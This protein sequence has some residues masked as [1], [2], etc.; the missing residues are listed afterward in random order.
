MAPSSTRVRAIILFTVVGVFLAA[1]LA[2]SAT[3]RASANDPP[4]SAETDAPPA[5]D[6]PSADAIASRLVQETVSIQE[7]ESVLI[8]GS[9]RD[10]DLMESL[11]V[12]VRKQGAFPLVTLQNETMLKRMYDEVPAE[13]DRQAPDLSLKMLDIVSVI[14]DISYGET[15]GLLDEVDPARIAA[16]AEANAAVMKK[17]RER[18]IRTV[19]IGNGLYPTSALSERSGL[20]K[21]RL[22]TLFWNGVGT[23]PDLLTR[24]GEA[25]REAL[26]TGRTLRITDDNGTDL[27]MEINADR[28][29]IS[30]GRISAD[31]LDTN[32]RSVWLPAG[33]LFL[34]PEP[35]SVQGTLTS[36]LQ[37][38]EGQEIRNLQM[39]FENGRMTEMTADAG[40]DRLQALY[41]E[42]GDA[43]SEFA[44]LD[45]G[46]NRSIPAS[47]DDRLLTWMAAGMVTVGIGNDV[48][49]G[50]DNDVPFAFYTHLKG[51]TVT[52][53][54]RTIVD[55]GV[56]QVRTMKPASRE[57]SAPAGASPTAGRYD[58]TG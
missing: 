20:S 2:L 51:V 36:A 13:Y 42:S 14:I 15:P 41:R 5:T 46:L 21:D 31:D 3:D 27:R 4:I 25:V 39:T 23:D 28:A 33:E 49:A 57:A 29:R 37:Y 54:D 11:A 34:V 9:P 55:R 47:N 38:F 17:A 40:L 24:T 12:H 10:L 56:L 58:P 1:G 22:A 32:N 8:V 45:F 35:G 44:A 43:A 16:R 53:D 19:E 26:R 7:G 30:D 6:R 52:V 18:G 48:W 50:G